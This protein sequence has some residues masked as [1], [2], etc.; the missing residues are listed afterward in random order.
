LVGFSA[1]GAGNILAR[2]NGS[3]VIK[4]SDPPGC[5]FHTSRSRDYD[6]LLHRVVFSRSATGLG[7]KSRQTMSA[8]VAAF[9][10]SGR[11]GFVPKIARVL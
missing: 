5:A 1:G 3:E 9:T 4:Q 2:L 7:Q 10:E 11:G 8:M 6:T